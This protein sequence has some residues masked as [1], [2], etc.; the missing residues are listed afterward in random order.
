[1][2]R[3]TSALF[4]F[5][6]PVLV[7]VA[8]LVLSCWLA[9]PARGDDFDDHLAALKQQN[10]AAKPHDDHAD[11][12]AAKNGVKT[13]CGCKGDLTLCNCAVKDCACP[14]CLAARNGAGGCH[15]KG[16]QC[17][18][19]CEGYCN[20]ITCPFRP[21]ID[22]PKVGDRKV[23]DDPSRPWTYAYGDGYG[24]G[25]ELGWYRHAAAAPVYYPSVGPADSSPGYHRLIAPRFFGGGVVNCGPS[26]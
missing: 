2:N 5:S 1:M 3:K 14:E 10:A 21:V 19:D 22:A 13:T 4:A 18:H 9:L 15:C 8:A 11:P 25:H 6:W 24:Y 12:F 7:F 17:P 26:G 16:D 23:T 20:D